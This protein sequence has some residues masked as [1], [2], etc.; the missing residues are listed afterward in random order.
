MSKLK[1]FFILSSVF[2]SNFGVES[3]P[4]ELS[5]QKCLEQLGFKCPVVR[6]DIHSVKDL[7][8]LSFLA[9]HQSLLNPS[10][11]K[12]CEQLSCVYDCVGIVQ[13][14]EIDLV[15]ND[16][17]ALTIAAAIDFTQQQ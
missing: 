14:I 12:A 17:D 11:L 10:D 6:Q 9:I 16:L 13:T 4:Q 8:I 1:L 15:L 7:K 3:L 2:I 5:C